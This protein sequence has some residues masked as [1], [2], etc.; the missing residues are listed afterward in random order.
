M[1]D[2][3]TSSSA[4]APSS[5]ARSSATSR[6]STISPR[7]APAL[8]ASAKDVLIERGTM[9]LYH[10][11]PRVDD[12]YRVPHPAGDGDHQSRL[13]LRHGAGPE[14]GRISA[15]RRV[16][17]LHARLGGAARRREDADARRLRARLPARRRSRGCRRETGEPD[18]SVVGYCFGGVLSLLWAALQPDAAL[19]N[20]VTFTTPVDFSADGDVPGVGR[21]TL[22]RCRPAGRHAS[23]TAPATISTPRSTCSARAARA[24]G[25][26]PAVRQSARRR[27]RE[28]AS[29]C[30]IA[31]RPTSCRSRANISARRRKQ[32]MWDNRAAPRHDGRRRPRGRSRRDHRAVPPRRRA[33]TT[34]SSRPRRRR[35]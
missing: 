7:A 30:S 35:R 3:P 12:V 20:L 8:G 34:I 24:G 28:V 10:Y 25:Q 14:P 32:L 11:R 13:H 17:R 1:A 23:A 26:H 19:Q 29:A 21:P 31:G 2:A 33:S 16:R 5:I 22:L 15:R 6:G 18:V 27:I 4:R 9:R